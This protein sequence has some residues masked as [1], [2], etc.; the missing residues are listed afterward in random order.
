M[1]LTPR[2][3]K[4]AKNLSLGNSLISQKNNQKILVVDDSR[5]TR[6]SIVQ[7]LKNLNQKLNLNCDIIEGFDG[8]D[9]L[10]YIIDDQKS[11]SR[12]IKCVF[13]DECMEYIN[14][15]KSLKMLKE[16]ES[17]NKL[18]PVAKVSITSFDDEHSQNF[19]LDIGA[20]YV[21]N[22]PCSSSS[23]EL[24]LREIFELR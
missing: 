18:R 11:N 17:S 7:L 20:D 6:S 5:F 22:K 14:G 21:L 3:Q 9:T 10:K 8:I 2:N 4:S 16:L 15:S 24:I 12:L 19:L 1:T 23:L 13:T